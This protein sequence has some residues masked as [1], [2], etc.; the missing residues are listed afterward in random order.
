MQTLLCCCTTAWSHKP[1]LFLHF[2]R[3]Q[4]LYLILL[5][6]N[7]S[8]LPFNFLN[9]FSQRLEQLN[10]YPDFNNYLIFVLTKLKSEGKLSARLSIA[11]YRTCTI[12]LDHLIILVHT[13]DMSF[14]CSCSMT[15][16]FGHDSGD[17][18]WHVCRRW[19]GTQNMG[20]SNF[21]PISWHPSTL[22]LTVHS[23]WLKY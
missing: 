4:I 8:S 5:Q 1:L 13:S 7:I 21:K 6:C 15:G 23:R 14:L 20:H 17:H 18:C 16:L 2:S 12:V 9:H 22:G 11:V 19:C 10:Q 3:W